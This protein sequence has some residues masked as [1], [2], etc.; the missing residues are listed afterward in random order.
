[1][2]GTVQQ[3]TALLRRVSAGEAD[4]EQAVN[5]LYPLVE[6]ELR[7]IASE[8]LRRERPGHTLQATM[9]LDDAF[10][11]L[12]RDHKISWES[13]TQFYAYAARIMRQILVSH[14]RKQ[15][16]QRRGGAPAAAAD[17]ETEQADRSPAPSTAPARR[18]DL[19]EAEA[20]V[21]TRDPSRVLE[22]DEVLTEF[23]TLHPDEALLVELH[24]FGGW[25]LKRIAEEILGISYATAKRRWDFAKA[26]LRRKLVGDGG[27]DEI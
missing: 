19:E 14:Y 2:S 7:R 18:V 3:V 6:A 4:A 10:L 1:M 12:V 23:A 5:E 15:A 24:V 11:L 9:L 25:D 21:D 26:W 20:I 17:P 13:R 16:A 27:C 8:Y 22:L